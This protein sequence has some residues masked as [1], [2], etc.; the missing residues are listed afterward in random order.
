M[1]KQVLLTQDTGKLYVSSYTN[2]T[3]LAKE[4][5]DIYTR[6]KER[7]YQKEEEFVKEDYECRLDPNDH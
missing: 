2:Q 5:T 6:F 1:L 4:C 7:I 3:K